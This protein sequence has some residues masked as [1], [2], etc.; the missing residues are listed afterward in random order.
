MST[1]PAPKP[2][3]PVRGTAEARRYMNAVSQLPCICCGKR[4]VQLHHPIMGRHSQGKSSDFDVIPLCA[5]P[6][7]DEL[8]R[9]RLTW[10]ARYG[11][12]VDLVPRVRA[13]VAAMEANSV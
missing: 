3:K 6:C 8:H 9:N 11:L 13:L 12:D 5:Y 7:H 4:P 10:I 1:R 2:Q